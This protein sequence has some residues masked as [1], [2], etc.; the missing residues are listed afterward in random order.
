MLRPVNGKVIETETVVMRA[1]A[2]TVRWIRADHRYLAKF[3]SN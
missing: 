1:A 2:G 3:Q